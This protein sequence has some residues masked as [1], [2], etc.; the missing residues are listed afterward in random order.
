MRITVSV[1]SPPRMKQTSLEKLL[2]ISLPVHVRASNFF[3]FT[4]KPRGIFF[5]PFPPPASISCE[6]SPAS[7]TSIPSVRRKYCNAPAKISTTRKACVRLTPHAA[8]CEARTPENRRRNIQYGQCPYAGA[9]NQRNHP[10][11]KAAPAFKIPGLHSGNTDR[12]RLKSAEKNEQHGISH[13]RARETGRCHPLQNF[14][15]QQILNEKGP[16]ASAAPAGKRK[17]RVVRPAS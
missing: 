11:G 15:H 5:L 10:E 14:L 17:H 12:P 4:E 9:A 6:T 3:S 8:Q 1:L 2:G 16:H 7:R 13:Q